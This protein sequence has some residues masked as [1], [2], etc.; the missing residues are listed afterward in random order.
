MKPTEYR[1]ALATRIPV[2]LME[3]LDKAAADSG[4]TKAEIIAEALRKHLK[5]GAK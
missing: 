5:G 1:V 4:K 3:A 2:S